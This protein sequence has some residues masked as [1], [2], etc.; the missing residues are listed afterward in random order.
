MLNALGEWALRIADNPK[1]AL[2]L[3]FALNVA[4]VIALVGGRFVH[5]TVEDGRWSIQPA[6][7][8]L[9][10][11]VAELLSQPGRRGELRSLLE[12]QRFFEISNDNRDVQPITAAIAALP[13]KHELVRELRDLAQR[14]EQPFDLKERNVVLTVSDRKTIAEGRAA[15]C[16][17]EDDLSQKWLLVRNPDGLGGFEVQVSERVACTSPE[18]QL[19][20]LSREDWE[21]LGV[22]AAVAPR[23][24]CAC[25]S[26]S[27]RSSSAPA[28]RRL[29]PT[30]PPRPGC[31]RPAQTLHPLEETCHEAHA[32]NP[33][34]N[35]RA[36]R[37]GHAGV[38]QLHVQ[39]PLVPDRLGGRRPG[40]HGE[41]K[42]AAPLR[43]RLQPS[44]SGRIPCRA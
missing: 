38:R 37:P 3:S 22:R 27:R 15:V 20:E 31:D 5:F 28:R 4:L 39:R 14:N 44:R 8:E 42:L 41:R 2:L 6:N 25:T 13:G 19:V 26:T 36:R 34:R 23:R 40:L 29:R 16:E 1:R 12:E 21:K 33:D 43:A 17:R 32:E 7:R 10:A 30:R 18:K 9:R 35:A 24:S 11:Q